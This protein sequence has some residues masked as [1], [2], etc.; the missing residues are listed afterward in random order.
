MKKHINE[1]QLGNIIYKYISSY[2]E[3]SK[4]LKNYLSKKRGKCK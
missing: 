3:I 4:D 1:C 2:I